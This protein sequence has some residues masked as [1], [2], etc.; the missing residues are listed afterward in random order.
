MSSQL[1]YFYVST[2][3]LSGFIPTEMTKLYKLINC[4]LHENFLSGSLPQNLGDMIQVQI[5]SAH[6]NQLTGRIPTSIF[7][8]KL[9]HQI[10]L[11]SNFLTG[12]VANIYNASEQKLLTTIDFSSNLLTGVIPISIFNARHLQSFVAG[13]NCFTGTLPAEICNAGRLNYLSLDGMNTAANCRNPLFPSFTGIN[14]YSRTQGTF[15]E[16]SLI[17]CLTCPK[18]KHSTCVALDSVTLPNGP[19]YQSVPHQ[20]ITVE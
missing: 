19:C 11:Q 9:L 20:L 8:M 17:A 16:E 14:S 2:N 3:L 18:S 6:F 13:T 10:Y 12:P 7:R 5:F 1:N 4:Y 15:K